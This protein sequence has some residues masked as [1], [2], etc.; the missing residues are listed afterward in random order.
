MIEGTIANRFS[1]RKKQSSIE[2]T[3]KSRMYL[4]CQAHC[5]EEI[6]YKEWT[7]RTGMNFVYASEIIFRED[8]NAVGSSCTRAREQANSC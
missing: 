5:Q 1:M 7:D 6:A 4:T 3:M 2:V 8:L